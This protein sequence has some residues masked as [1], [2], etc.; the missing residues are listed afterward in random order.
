MHDPGGDVVERPHGYRSV[1]T[2]PVAPT[3]PA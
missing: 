2:T 3:D 1:A